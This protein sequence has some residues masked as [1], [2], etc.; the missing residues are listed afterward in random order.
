MKKALATLLLLSFCMALVGCVS[1]SYE[2]T[3]SLEPLQSWPENEYTAEIPQPTIDDDSGIAYSAV[4]DST[5]QDTY[6][7]IIDGLTYDQYKAYQS[8]LYDAGYRLNRNAHI[9]ES[10]TTPVF[11]DEPSA[12]GLTVAETVAIR[13]GKEI[14]VATSVSY[15]G[16]GTTS[17]SLSYHVLT[18]DGKTSEPSLFINI[19]LHTTPFVYSLEEQ[20]TFPEN[21]YSEW[22]KAPTFAADCTI[23]SG[24]GTLGEKDMYCI[25]L[26]GVS[27]EQY[28]QYLELLRES[29]FTEPS[30]G[31]DVIVYPGVTADGEEAGD[32]PVGI[33]RPGTHI[34]SPFDGISD[35]Y[36]QP[37]DVRWQGKI[38]KEATDIYCYVQYNSGKSYTFTNDEVI[39]EA[40]AD[41]MM[42]ICIMSVEGTGLEAGE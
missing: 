3:A 42:L 16:K 35:S 6:G 29:G 26:D 18:E 25:R 21:E 17:V 12:P 38:T 37:E 15:W 23:A 27:S 8:A 36:Y 22:I 32:L 30:K 2:S 20:D 39:N 28:N 13:D 14:P 19:D 11:P 24:R 40:I 7:I 1:V 34:E 9:Y 41:P 5:W 4:T 31:S 10:G 33:F